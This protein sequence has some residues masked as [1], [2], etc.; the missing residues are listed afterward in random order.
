V[1]ALIILFC[2]LAALLVLPCMLLGFSRKQG[3]A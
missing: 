1:V 2:L 3:H